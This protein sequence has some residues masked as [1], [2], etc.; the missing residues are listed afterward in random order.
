MGRF[1]I[2][3]RLRY[4]FDNLMAGGTGVQVAALAIA[5]AVIVLL[6]ALLVIATGNVPEGEEGQASSFGELLWN[7]LI[8]TL[9]PAMLGDATGRWVFAAVMLI[10]ALGGIF[11]LSALIGILTG[12]FERVVEELRKGKSAVV[13]RNHSVVLGFSPKVH[14]ILSELAE[15]GANQ[16]DACVVVLAPR[17][18]VEMDDEIRQLLGDRKLRVVTR[19]GDPL[20]LADLELANLGDSKSV[21]ILAPETRGDGTSV[22]ADEADTVVLKT[23]LALN[24]LG[25]GLPRPLHLV[26]EIQ[27]EATLDVARMVVGDDAALILVPPLIGR[28]MVQTGRQS[29]LSVVYSELLDFAGDEIYMTAEPSLNGKTFHQ[30]LAAY[31][32]SAVIGVQ[33]SNHELMMPPAFDRKMQ[34]GDRIVA[35]SRDDDTLIPNGRPGATTDAIV[36]DPPARETR[37]ERTLVLGANAR[38]ALVLGELDTYVADGS[39]TSVIGEKAG[40]AELPET[41]APVH[42]MTVAFRAADVT[43]RKVLDSLEIGTFDHI[44]VL[45][46]STERS[47]ELADA[48]TMITLLHLRDI[49]RKSGKSVPITSEIID[50]QN[51]DLAAVAEPDDFIISNTLV[52]LLLSQVSE[53][54]HLVGVFDELFSARGSEIYLKPAG[55]FIRE[56]AEVSFYDVVEAAARQ[57]Q[58]AIGYRIAAKSRDAEAAFGVVVNPKKSERVELGAGDQVIV[59]ADQ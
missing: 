23:L 19:S 43:S 56:G 49:A 16:R 55:D 14:T 5:T 50:I 21:I 46:E 44:L 54:R 9:D 58:V 22:S 32:D 42:N 51:R 33:T 27:Q 35:I 10:A 31:E 36:T 11:V 25:A 45:S 8:Y 40:L 13:E 48:R 47:Q 29:G 41:G 52:S 26:A 18:K 24:K 37:S 12:G 20:L 17:D 53:N 4:R 7:G 3:Q 34:A 59:V 1:T 15:A 28:L 38:L 57:G 30:V 39:E 6:T 2:R